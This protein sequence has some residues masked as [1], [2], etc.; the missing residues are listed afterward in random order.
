MRDR[1]HCDKMWRRRGDKNLYFVRP[2]VSNKK[3]RK[4]IFERNQNI[5]YIF[6]TAAARISILQNIKAICISEKNIW[7]KRVKRMYKAIALNCMHTYT[8]KKAA[9]KR[10]FRFSSL[11]AHLILLSHSL[12]LSSF[13]CFSFSL[14]KKIS[15]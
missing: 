4:N 15:I 8:K 5:I 14:H 3:R 2:Q 7:I 1:N 6:S 12:T 9:I 11:N 10:H 13:C